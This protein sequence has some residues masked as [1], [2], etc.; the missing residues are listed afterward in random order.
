MACLLKSY[1]GRQ[2]IVAKTGTFLW[3]D[4]WTGRGVTQGNPASPMIFNIVMDAVVWAVLDV[5][6]QHQ[7]AQ[8][9]LVWAAGERNVIFM[10][11]MARY[12]G[13]ITSGFRMHYQ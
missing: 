12:R 9:V 7:D 1:W 13:G 3:K 11:E 4:F 10:L 8:H 5:V 6:C 2:R